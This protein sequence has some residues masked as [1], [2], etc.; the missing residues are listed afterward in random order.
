MTATFFHHDDIA[1]SEQ[2]WEVDPPAEA[3]RPEMRTSRSHVRHGDGHSH[4]HETQLSSCLS[5]VA[6]NVT[7]RSATSSEYQENKEVSGEITRRKARQSMAVV[8]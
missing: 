3:A 1:N 2:G 6:A 5:E 7:A 4:P 8:G